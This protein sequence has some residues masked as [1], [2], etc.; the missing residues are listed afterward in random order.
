ML[1]AYGYVNKQKHYM[2]LHYKLTRQLKLEESL[3]WFY[4]LALP[5]ISSQ[6][7]MKSV[8]CLSIKME[9]ELLYKNLNVGTSF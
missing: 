2:S 7:E 5:R 1:F 6:K 9:S 3:V 4:A 8:I